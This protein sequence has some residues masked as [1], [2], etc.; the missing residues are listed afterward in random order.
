MNP[1]QAKMN[2]TKS[3]STSI[4]TKENNNNDERNNPPNNFLPTIPFKL[5]SYF[6]K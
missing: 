2:M 6:E 4:K 5:K 3:A 1:K